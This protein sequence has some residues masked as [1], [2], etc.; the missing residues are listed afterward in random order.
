M[1][2]AALE[3]AQPEVAAQIWPPAGEAWTEAPE[4]PEVSLPE[5]PAA[6]EVLWAG[7]AGG[8]LAGRLLR[9][10]GRGRV[11]LW[12]RDPARLQRFLE[13][14]PIG[15]AAGVA[16][17]IGA[18][19]LRLAVG[20]GL[21]GLPV[22]PVVAHPLLGHL[23]RRELAWHA[24]AHA[25]A[26]AGARRAL[27]VD[28][29]LLVDEV[30]LALEAA[31][32][33]VWTWE[34]RRAAPAALDGVARAVGAAA[35][36]AGVEAVFAVNHVP[37]LAEAAAGLGARLHVWEID[38][39]LD[40]VAP[41]GSAGAAGAARIHSYRR[42]SVEAFRAA[43]WRAGYLP[44]ATDPVKR[45]PQALTE[46]EQARY[47]APVTFVGRSMVPEA[48]AHRGALVRRL[49]AA[50]GMP[51][52]EAE[53]ALEAVLSRQRAINVWRLPEY[54]ASAGLDRLP[55]QSPEEPETLAQLS[56][57]AASEQRLSAMARLGR[58]LGPGQAAVWGDQ[59]WSVLKTYG[60]D[61]RGP[62]G[63]H[64]EINR[65]YSNGGVHIDLPRLY[66]ADIV[67]LRVFEV[68][69]CGGFLIA[70]DCPALRELFTVGEELAAWG[71]VEDLERQIRYWS[72]RPE[73]RARI[74]AAGR[75]RV[76]RDHTVRAR[77]AE[78]MRR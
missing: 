25:G 33:L 7:A 19:G 63:H 57:I 76:E 18:G 72:A 53:A 20:A 26:G 75:R 4:V 46:A 28:G 3:E 52:A 34:I 45:Q 67:T 78:M 58:A 77:L 11:W 32:F 42:A 38:P 39:A 5:V 68:L 22:M 51:E 54:A 49:A 12:D 10:A 31:G 70:W 35:G 43:G 17:A 69:A 73:E 41:P 56:E 9:A 24:G 1:I 74:G 59:G 48:R 29:G 23:Y 61:W 36:G 64:L 65:I 13:R 21:I 6:P 15:L 2:R 37:G 62:A 40:R 14:L 8:E 44:L 55:A 27:L 66:Q 16:A 50:R 71:A 30:G 47:G 60:V